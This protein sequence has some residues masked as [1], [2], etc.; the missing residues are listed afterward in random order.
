MKSRGMSH[1]KQQKQLIIFA[2]GVALLP[3]NESSEII[4]DGKMENGLMNQPISYH[5]GKM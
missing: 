4:L 5:D 1:S 3:I 2:S